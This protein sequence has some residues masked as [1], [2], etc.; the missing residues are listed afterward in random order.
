MFR[1]RSWF[2]DFLYLHIGV[3][4][5]WWGPFESKGK[6][7]Y[8]LKLL[9]EPLSKNSTCRLQLL[10]VAP[11][12]ARNYTLHLLLGAPLK[13]SY[14]HITTAFGSLLESKEFYLTF[15]V[16]APLKT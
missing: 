3:G 7:S 2:E 13:P 11:L 12:K 10:L 5:S 8:I 1:Y 6:V 4:G 16:G 15:A 14:L 9:F